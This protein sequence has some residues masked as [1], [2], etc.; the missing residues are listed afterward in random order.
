MNISELL[1]IMNRFNYTKS[2]VSLGYDKHLTGIE[3][4]HSL[5]YYRI[6][7]SGNLYIKKSLRNKS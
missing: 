1:I 2:K 4:M 3:I 5:K 7:G 6:F